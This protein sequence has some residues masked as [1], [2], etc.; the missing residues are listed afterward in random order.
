MRKIELTKV[1]VDGNTIRYEVREEPGRGLL[2]QE[3]VELFI[4][5]HFNESF[6]CDLGDLPMSI[7]TLPISF[8]LIPLT[9][10]YDVEVMIPEMDKDLYEHL[11][12]IYAAYSKVYGPFNESWRGRVTV[13]KIVENFNRGNQR[14]DKAVFFSGGVDACHAGINN[15][16]RRS[17]LVSIPDIETQAKNEGPLRGEKF[18][19]IK[20]FSNT[21]DSD[22]L[23]ISNNFNSSLYK[24]QSINEF[25][26]KVRGLSSAAYKYDG[27][28]GIKYIPNMCSVAPVAYAM[29]IK[30]LHM[31]STCEEI[32]GVYAE[33]LDGVNPAITNSVS[34]AGVSFAEQDGLDARRSAKVR[35]IITWCKV[36]NKR[37]KLWACFSDRTSQ[38]GFC[39]K[40]VRTQLNVLCAGENPREWGFDEFSEKKF[41][42]FIRDYRYRES[43]PCWLWDNIDAIEDECVYPY[44]N[45]LLHWLKKI[46]YKEYVRRANNRAK[47]RAR[48]HMLSRVLFVNRYPCYVRAIWAKITGSNGSSVCA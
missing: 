17:L 48:M 15:A 10:F 8:Y 27:W 30:S 20:N 23:L 34:F 22:W 42:K 38:C 26:G 1:Y 29:G 13:K 11:P 35:K 18:A 31:G 43:N 16:G 5:Y 12:Q 37:V 19:L 46:G 25:L 33:N 21:V 40:C 9:Y 2:R 44:L 3:K 39:G 6:I 41:A 45:D 14:Y 7:L 4:R 28:Y 32:D 24:D 47:L 36:N